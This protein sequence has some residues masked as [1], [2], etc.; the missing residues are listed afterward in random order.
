MVEKEGLGLRSAVLF[1]VI[2]IVSWLCTA[3]AG[4]GIRT[5]PRVSCWRNRELLNNTVKIRSVFLRSLFCAPPPSR[6][7]LADK[8]FLSDKAAVLGAAIKETR[9][10]KLKKRLMRVWNSHFA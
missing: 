8:D 4:T 10:I 2:I 3:T 6:N 9:R 5:L 1:V 7:V